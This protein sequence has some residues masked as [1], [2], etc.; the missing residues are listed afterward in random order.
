MT[1]NQS[2]LRDHA[3]AFHALHVPGRPLVLP[4][5]WDA[6]SARL[7]E[8]AGAAAVAT[9]SAGLAWALGAV[10]G[11][12]LDRDRALEAVGR[13]VATVR[14][15]VSADIES[16]YA[17]DPAGVADTVRAVLAAGAVGVNIEDALYGEEESGP[18]R[19]VAG[20]A[21]R[22]AA[23]RAAADAE[24]VPLFVNARIDTI[25]RAAGGVDATLERAAAFRAAGADGIFVPGV[26]DPETVKALVEGVDGPLNVLV[27]PGA[28]AV[29]ELAA[30]GVARVSAGSG[31][32]EAAHASVRCAA[33]ELLDAGTYGALAG[34]LGYGELNTLLARES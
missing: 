9:T 24:G 34:G 28:P 31:L 26:V 11:D 6:V 21:E 23:A 30:L 19:S 3:L 7:A 8:D 10:D 22:I 20:Q 2:T 5:A 14:V 15:P 12:R 32:A 1:K 33:R 13:I 16:G 4:N 17:E 29:A 27:G 18:L 25:L